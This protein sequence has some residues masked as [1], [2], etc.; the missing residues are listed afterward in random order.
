[1][2]SYLAK[3][4]DW[5]I[6]DNQLCTI[7]G[8]KQVQLKIKPKIDKLREEGKLVTRYEA[9]NP[10]SAVVIRQ[11]A[12]REFE[13]KCVSLCQDYEVFNLCL[14]CLE[15]LTRELNEALDSEQG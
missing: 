4:K 6:Q 13:G 9:G 8:L 2:D 10:N 7:C 1:M 15:G 3:S 11:E 14:T 5:N 12:T